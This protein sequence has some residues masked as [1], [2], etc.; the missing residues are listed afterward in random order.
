MKAPA[1]MSTDLRILVGRIPLVASEVFKLPDSACHLQRVVDIEPDEFLE[2]AEEDLERGGAGALLNAVTNAKRAIHCQVD[3]VL[4][5]LGYESHALPTARKFALFE[6]FGFIAP[7]ILKRVTDLRNI[8][9][10]EYRRPTTDQVVDAVD[11]AALFV[12]GVGR[13]LRYFDDSFVLGHKNDLGP[14]MFRHHY[15]AFTYHD[16]EHRFRI[17]AGEQGVAD[18]GTVFVNSGHPV[19]PACVRLAAAGERESKVQDAVRTFIEAVSK[20]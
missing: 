5:C 3:Y 14:H 12:D 16:N 15:L 2:L 19:F 20:L 13:H 10:H 6:S 9:E 11:I 4:D 7:R 1:S 8:L 17:Q 18:F